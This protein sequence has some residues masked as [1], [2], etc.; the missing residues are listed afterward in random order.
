MKILLRALSVSW[1]FVAIALAQT[2]PNLNLNIPAVGTLNWGPLVNANF[3]SLDSFF[4]GGSPLKLQLANPGLFTN[5]TMNLNVTDV[6]NSLSFL[7]EFQ[8]D[9]SLGFATEG[10]SVGVATPGT[11]SLRQIN[12]IGAYVTTACN[13]NSRTVCNAVGAYMHGRVT[14]TGGGAWGANSLVSDTHGVSGANLTSFEADSNVAGTPAYMRGVTISICD[15]CSNSGTGTVPAHAAWAIEIGGNAFTGNGRWTTGINFD[16]AQDVDQAIELD[17]ASTVN[18][19]NSQRVCYTGYNSGGTAF[20]S[21]MQADTNGNL[22]VQ[23][24]NASNLNFPNL[25]GS[26]TTSY[27][28]GTIAAA[29]ACANTSLGATGH[30]IA[31]IATL[32]GGTSTITGISPAFTSS[33]TFFC[34]TNDITTIAN[35]SKAVPASGSTVTFTG[36]GTD[37]IQFVCM[38]S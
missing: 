4:S 6:V 16:R 2:T 32:S 18:P 11:A 31:G 5:T 23:T 33:S 35:P 37:N 29:G 13:S 3:S 19:S 10:L 20:Q 25:G 8:I 17:G 36:T 7:T 14:G 38:G 15:Q 9:Q 12:G 1:L 21:C 30:S 22:L 26:L 28:C 34:V 27:T 24:P